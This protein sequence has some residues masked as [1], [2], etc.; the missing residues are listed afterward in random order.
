MLATQTKNHKIYT[1]NS[2]SGLTI[3]YSTRVIIWHATV[4]SISATAAA[5]L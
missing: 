2:F 3:I 5:V 1:G 4:T